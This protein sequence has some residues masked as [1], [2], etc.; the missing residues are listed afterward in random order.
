MKKKI[1]EKKT[2]DL[3]ILSSVVWVLLL[4]IL[5]TQSLNDYDKYMIYSFLTLLIIF[6]TALIKHA[7]ELIDVLH[8]SLIIYVFLSLFSENIY[9]I[10]LFILILTVIFFYWI[11][12]NRCPI[13]NYETFEYIH[14][15]LISHPIE[16]TVIPI[17]AYIVLFYKLYNILMHAETFEYIPKSLQIP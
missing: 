4:T 12:D 14:C 9:L 16:S 8:M 13:G 1:P 5:L 15:L 11:R 7:D 2:T 6:V 3:I 17:F 10:E